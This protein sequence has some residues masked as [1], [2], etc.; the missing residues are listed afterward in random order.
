MTDR[1]HLELH[2]R[3]TERGRDSRYLNIEDKN[4]EDLENNYSKNMFQFN[5]F[6][7]KKITIF[8]QQKRFPNH[9][10]RL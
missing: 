1:E 4:C 5:Q 7:T 10:E 6:N 3:E 2:Q 9:Q 8:D